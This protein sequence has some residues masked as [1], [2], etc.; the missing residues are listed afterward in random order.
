[1]RTF[2]GSRVVRA[3]ALTEVITGDH[4]DLEK[5]FKI[6]VDSKDI[7]EQERYGNQFIWELARHSV[8]EEL[9]VY[10]AMERYMEN[11]AGKQHAEKD[12]KQHHAVS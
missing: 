11:N 6:V 5:Y 2:R 10:P 8:A 1:M 12:R 9:I 7:E 4:R 3:P